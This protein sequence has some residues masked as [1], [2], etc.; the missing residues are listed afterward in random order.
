MKEVS[1]GYLPVILAI[2]FTILNFLAVVMASHIYEKTR[3]SPSASSLCGSVKKKLSLMGI[4]S[5]LFL[6]FLADLSRN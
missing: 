1:H 3:S 6:L 4:S 2:L 5:V